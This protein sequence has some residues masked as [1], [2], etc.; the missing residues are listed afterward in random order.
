MRFIG[1]SAGLTDGRAEQRD[2]A[3]LA[4]P[5]PARYSSMKASS[6]WCQHL[7][8]LAAVLVEAQPPAATSRLIVR[9]FLPTT[10]PMRTKA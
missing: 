5:A 1:L 8:A 2:L 9:T 10:A 3:I 7:V 6:L 4:D